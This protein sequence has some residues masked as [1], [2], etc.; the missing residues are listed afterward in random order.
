MGRVANNCP[1]QR[2]TMPLYEYKCECGE[3]FEALRG[4]EDR[5]NV[6]CECGKVPKLKISKWGRVLVAGWFT[7]VG[8]DGTILSRKQVVDDPSP[9]EAG[10]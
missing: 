5:H 8:G 1:P 2:D 6:V 3:E 4:I 7:V 9:L 10:L